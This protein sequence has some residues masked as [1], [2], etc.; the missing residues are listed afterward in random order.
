VALDDKA[1]PLASK[2]SGVRVFKDKL[3]ADQVVLG[4]PA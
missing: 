4:A 3:G 1:G 2:G